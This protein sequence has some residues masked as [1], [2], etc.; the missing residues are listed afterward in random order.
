MEILHRVDAAVSGMFL[1]PRDCQVVEG[2]P[3]LVQWAVSKMH[4]KVHKWRGAVLSIQKLFPRCSILERL[5]GL[6]IWQKIFEIKF[7]QDRIISWR[8]S[9]TFETALCAVCRPLEQLGVVSLH[10][11]PDQELHLYL[12]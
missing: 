1:K 11:V 2:G 6:N 8:N 5:T 4:K 9:S 7:S 3:E 12:I 10:P